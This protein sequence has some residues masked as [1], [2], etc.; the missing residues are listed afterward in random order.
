MTQTAMDKKTE[1]MLLLY[2]RLFDGEVINKAE[3]AEECQVNVRSIQRD[4]D[5]LRAYLSNRSIETGDIQ[6]ICYDRKLGGYYLSHGSSKMTGSEILAVCKII[7]ESRAFTKKELEPI[8]RKLLYN[9]AIPSERKMITDL[10]ANEQYHYIEPHH[11]TEFI[12]RMWEIGTAVKEQR[13]MAIEYAKL[14]VS[15]TVSRLVKPVGIMFSEFYFYLIAYIES[16]ITK[17]QEYDSPAI[18][19]IDRIKSFVVQDRRFAVPYK[20][21][22]EEGE[23]RKR[24]QFMHGGELQR[25]VFEYSG[26]S[27]EAILDRLPTAVVLEEKD[28]SDGRKCFLI[29]A[30][31]FG[32]GVDMW[33]KSQGDKVRIISRNR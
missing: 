26:L 29:R 33:L 18:Y 14:G 32:P 17:E 28:N 12:S 22:F 5:D 30:E 11:Q 31:V 4:I 7:L 13:Y 8:M 1:R 25:I 9:C 10:I 24:V 27:L 20:N 21:R 16:E 19:R 23:F 2:Q 3:M 15:D 6:D